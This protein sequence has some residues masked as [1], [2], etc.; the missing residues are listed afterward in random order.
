MTEPIEDKDQAELDARMA[1]Y[2]RFDLYSKHCLKIQTESADLVPFNLN[3]IQK[4]L[5]KIIKHIRDNKRLIRLIILKARREGISTWVSGRFYWKTTSNSNR[6]ALTIAHD[7]EST[8]FL[9]N[10]I[11]RYNAHCPEHFKPEEKYN[12]K[13]IL[14][15]NTSDGTGLDSAM[16]VGCAGKEDLGSGMK[17]DYLH[18]SEVAKWDRNVAAALF[19]SL[20]QTVPNDPGTEVILE[21]TAKGVGG[22]FYDRFWAARHV[23]TVKIKDGVPYFE[24][25]INEKADP[26]NEYSAL[27]FPWFVDG[28]YQMDIP[29]GFDR[30][31]EEKLLVQLYGLT[32]RQL[33]WRRWCISNKCGGKTDIYKQEYPSNSI[34]C[35]L[36]GG[37]SVF[38]GERIMELIDKAPKP[39]ARYEIQHGLFDVVVDEKN[40]RFLVWEEPKA[41]TKYILA[42]DVSEGLLSDKRDFSSVDVINHLTGEQV[43]NWHG[44]VSPDTLG[45][46]IYIIGRRYGFAYAAIERNNHGIGVIERL[47]DLKYPNLYVETQHEPPHK[48][49][50]RYGWVTHKTNK[51]AMIDNLVEEVAQNTHKIRCAGT[52]KEMLTYKEEDG[53][54]MAEQGHF[55]DHV[56]S[57]A[58][59][60]YIRRMYPLPSKL[61]AI[62]EKRIRIQ[63]TTNPVKKSFR[64]GAWG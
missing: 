61:K 57:I 9:F 58:I 3:D 44:K 59:A 34:E 4:V 47:L 23:Y 60:K 46:I 11:K 15:F 5:Q 8:D 53:E 52:F 27:F 6:Y 10:M 38:P 33:T 30:T 21:S 14:D 55:D 19:T 43:A 2:G 48:P 32:D 16:R 36:A 40:G 24:Y 64:S 39:K 54:L 17:I 50:K 20:L 7:P 41:N 18:G 37:V 13:K 56:V 28:R 25:T 12:N 42:A 35:F 22:E 51:P 31:E 62:E 63:S 26:M 49:R 45:K 1:L 29:E